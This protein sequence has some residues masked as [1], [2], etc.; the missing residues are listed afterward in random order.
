[1]SRLK[2]ALEK[3]KMQRLNQAK[4]DEVEASELAQQEETLFP[5]NYAGAS[6]S[7]VAQ[8]LLLK[9]RIVTIDDTHPASEQFKFLRTQIFQ[10]TREKKWNVIQVTGFGTGEGKSLVAANLALSIAKDLRQSALL[11]DLDLRRPSQHRLFSLAPDAP[12]LKS[13]LLGEVAF[14]QMLVSPGIEKLTLIPAGGSLLRATEL[15]GSPRME[16]LLAELKKRYRDRYIVIDTPGINVCPDPLI[17]SEYVDGIVLVARAGV[18]TKTNI[19]AALDRIPKEKI[20]CTVLNGVGSNEL[21]AYGYFSGHQY[22][23][24]GFR[25]S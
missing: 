24:E 4:L 11:V 2:A 18:T 16:A 7:D 21:S 9:N 8:E 6:V 19:K 22:A 10:Y 23:A 15:L 14:E 5:V 3:A 1:M 20:L 13:F 12:G 17:I 25:P